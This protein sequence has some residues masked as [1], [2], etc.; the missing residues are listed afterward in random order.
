MSNNLENDRSVTTGKMYPI[1]LAP[2]K[3][4]I[5][6][7]MSNTEVKMAHLISGQPKTTNTSQIISH[8]GTGPMGLMRT[9]A[10][11]I[12]P[13]V[14]SQPQ[15]IVSGSPILQGTHAVSQGSQHIGQNS[16]IISPSQLIPSG[17]LLSPGTQIISQGTQ[18]SMQ[19]STSSNT[20]SSSMP[21]TS[22]N[23]PPLLNVGGLSGA[24]N[25]VVSSSVRTL[26]PSVRVLP[27]MP[28]QNTRPVL[29]S[30]NVNSTGS[31]LVSKGVTSHVPR[32]LAA[33]ASL[34]VRPVSNSQVPANPGVWSNNRGGRGGRALVYG[35][36]ARSPAPPGPRA[37]PPSSL[38]QPPPAPQ[39]AQSP[40]STLVTLPTT[41]VLTTGVI[42]TTA[43][44]PAPRTPT[45][46]HPAPVGP[47]ALPLLQRNYQ[48]TKVV[49]V[50]GVGVRGVGNSAPPQLYYEV[51]RPSPQQQQSN[52]QQQYQ[53]SIPHQL[54]RPLT[55]Y[56]HANTLSAQVSV[57]SVST[58]P[59]VRQPQTSIQNSSVLPRPSILRKR[60]VEG[61]PTKSPALLNAVNAVN[62][63]IGTNVASIASIGNI[64][65]GNHLNIG[66]VY[67]SE[68][69]GWEDV[70]SGPGGAGTGSTTISAPSSPVPDIDPDPPTPEQDL[71][72]RKKPRKQTLINEV[73]Q[74][75]FPAEESVMSPPP[76]VPIAPPPKRPSLSSTYVCG[77]RSTALHF[78]RPSD[79]R[80]R[81]PRARDI[82]AI[83]SQKHV[84]TSAEGWKVHHLT[85]QM[86]DLVSLEA[87]VGEQLVGVL[88]AL[89]TSAS[90]A[91]SPIHTI[92]HTLLELIKGNIQRSKIVC[93]GIQEAREDILRVFK[94][95][96]FVSDILTRQADKRCFR[97]H[98]SQS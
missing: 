72:P 68:N 91:H 52:P 56:G 39:P 34:A 75:E 73:R 4:T 83:A 74:C 21:N 67:R 51:P 22:G 15:M 97:K 48:P 76:V 98:R 79:V 6:K 53:Q 71:S 5:V 31:V 54:P 59:E 86:D 1:D 50:A 49:G 43:R 45:P 41:S 32:G 82:V 89:E 14:A 7:T 57:N 84:L 25:L 13:G 28:Q 81:E 8:G 78:T 93:E 88:R 94:H 16:Q 12:S 36:R 69:T 87:D 37:P 11:I 30:M 3:I 42:S 26:P 33:G 10:Q 27:P 46:T 38:S 63:I 47:R 24:G 55:P 85:A 20:V 66:T 62:T 95:R 90:R 61:S 77:W 65:L 17:Q 60:D 80:R 23:G 2:Q 29:S 70:P 96:N 19:G 40:H 18:L 44:G 58:Q 35:C 64:S 9:A 92:Q